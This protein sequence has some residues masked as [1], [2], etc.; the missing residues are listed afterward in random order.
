MN[1]QVLVGPVELLKSSWV[2]FKTHWQILVS[3]VIVPNVLNY[4]ASLLLQTGKI[5]AVFLGVFVSIIAIILSFA[6]AAALVRSV[7]MLSGEPTKIISVKDQ[8]KIGFKYFWPLILVGIIS[9]LAAMGA[10]MLL[11]VPGII[12]SVYGGLYAYALIIDGKKG[13]SA[14][15]ESYSLVYNRWLAVFGRL[16]VIT[17][18]AVIVQ[19]LLSGIYFLVALMFGVNIYSLAAAHQ[20]IP[21]LITLIGFVF[22]LAVQVIVGPMAVIYTYYL[23]ESLKVTRSQDVSVTAFKRWIVAFM[24]IGPIFF[25]LFVV[26]TVAL[27]G[28]QA[29][30]QASDS[31]RMISSPQFQAQLQELIKQAASTTPTVQIKK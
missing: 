20:Q 24:I 23:Y 22:N 26:S 17:A 7:Q 18:V 27:V 2:F 10:F 16:L 28:L 12:M 30:R 15:T 9:S 5:A 6:M 13:F 8:Y 31:Q 29:T 3:I 4:V 21:V 14:L 19:I 25:L 11:I 1:P